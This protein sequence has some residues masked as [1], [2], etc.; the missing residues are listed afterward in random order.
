MPKRRGSTPRVE[1]TAAAAVPNYSAV[2]TTAGV[3]SPWNPQTTPRTSHP[4]SRKGGKPY[5]FS[6]LKNQ[7]N[8]GGQ[9][10]LSWKLNQLMDRARLLTQEVAKQ[11]RL[12]K[13]PTEL[14]ISH[15]SERL[16]SVNNSIIAI[17][18]GML[19]SIDST[20]QANRTEV[21]RT[22]E[23]IGQDNLERAL[24]LQGRRHT[25]GGVE[26]QA[27][28]YPA[29]KS[30]RRSERAKRKPFWSRPVRRQDPHDLISLEGP[31][32]GHYLNAVSRGYLGGPSQWLRSK[33]GRQALR[34]LS[35]KGM[36]NP[37][38]TISVY[39]RG[40]PLHWRLS[41][42]G[43]QYTGAGVDGFR[44][45][46]NCII[47]DD[48]MIQRQSR[49]VLPLPLSE[50][51]CGSQGRL[52]P[53]YLTFNEC[54]VRV[55]EGKPVNRV[56]PDPPSTQYRMGKPMSYISVTTRQVQRN[57]ALA[58]RFLLQYFIGIR[59]DREIPEKF[60][61]YFKYR[62]GFLILTRPH[63]IPV[64]LVRL[65]LSY[66]IT[67]KRSMLLRESVSYRKALYRTKSQSVIASWPYSFVPA[68]F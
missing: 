8:A 17:S 28:V 25:S 43:P 4:G 68:T 41:P 54:W 27:T 39:D 49:G 23:S 15:A 34:C 33:Y 24:A 12:A 1:A 6:G 48:T 10:N 58:K 66:W 3:G 62:W 61:V 42:N 31:L 59:A 22:V 37:K 11:A 7:R 20:A 36:Y 45:R 64:G 14:V 47:V 30:T 18:A 32:S 26:R 40:S 29:T 50:W 57:A 38:S 56:G 5:Q 44:R 55:L 67:H 46:H 13:L 9:P 51:P 19:E 60:L 63:N 35:S 16:R 65:L 21:L 52:W 53:S 2:S